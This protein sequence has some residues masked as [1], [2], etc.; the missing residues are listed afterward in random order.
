MYLCIDIDAFFV[1]VEQILDPSLKGKPVIVGALPGQRGVVTSASYEARVFGIRAGMP[2]SKAYRLCPRGLF[3]PS[4][5]REY[6]KFSRRFK[7]IIETYSPDVRMVS[8]DEAYINIKGTERLF[9]P[10]PVIA[11]RLKDQIRDEL[12]LPTSV[13]IARTRALSKIACD[14]SKPDGLLIL[15]PGEEM[16]FLS[17]LSVSA[18]PGIGPKHCEILNNLNIKTVKELFETPEQIL[19]TALGN[20]CKT[21]R[22]FLF[23]DDAP[24]RG[25]GGPP[26]RSVSRD[27]TLNEDTLNK[28]LLNALLYRLTEKACASLRSKNLIARVASVKIRFSDFKTISKQASIP[29]PTNCQ[30]KVYAY[31][32][33]LLANLMQEKKRVRLIGIALSRLEYDG[34]QPSLFAVKE[35]RWSH[36]NHALDRARDKLGSACLFSGNAYILGRKPQNAN[37]KS[38]ILNSKQI[39]KY[40]NRRC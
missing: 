39:P 38:E 5:F 24:A 16:E 11:R 35:E 20:Y 12:K 34:Q 8:I 17:P 25:I 30:Q 40:K 13:G 37:P 28:D 32:A 33:P 1:S 6:E 23:A 7:S 26:V 3:V 21:M 29:E 27:T 18:L 2:V 14:Q 10:P 15:E 36:V 31:A 9:G 19:S 22:P 4:H